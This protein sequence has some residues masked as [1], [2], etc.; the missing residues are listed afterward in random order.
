M[1]YFYHMKLPI[2]FALAAVL[3]PATL[4]TPGTERILTL[5]PAADNAAVIS[6]GQAVDPQTGLVVEGYALLQRHAA[7]KPAHAGG[8][9]GGSTTSSCYAFMA[10]G[11]KW[12]S[13]EPW[14]M[15]PSNQHGIDAAWLMENFSGSVQKWEAA[16]S[17]DILGAGTS[18][19]NPLEADT[20]TPDGVNEVLF[21]E[22]AD[23]GVIGVTIVWGVFGGPT[24]QRQLTEWDQ[25]YDEVD[26]N[27]STTGEA[28]KMDF[29]NISTH[30]LGHTIGLTHPG[31]TCNQETMYR[32]ANYGEIIRR[33]LN[34]GDIAGAAALY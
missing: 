1:L 2:V 20:V 31:D 12:K 19:S 17:V 29:E 7:A 32:Y 33:D 21:G 10:R 16:A 14:I 24:Q 34:A 30:E 8:G 26:F 5:P 15:N 25:V 27:W 23:P 28:G 13:V 4:V 9:N 11:A 22:I 6:L 3:N 18:T